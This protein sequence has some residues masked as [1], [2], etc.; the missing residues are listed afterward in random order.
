MAHQKQVVTRVLL[1]K[2]TY[3]GT[4]NQSPYFAGIITASMLWVGYCWVT[5]LVQRMLFAIVWQLQANITF[6]RDRIARLC[7]PGFRDYLWSM[8][9]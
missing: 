7:P 9:I 5:R 1:N 3:V 6:S 4:V 8:F 2:N